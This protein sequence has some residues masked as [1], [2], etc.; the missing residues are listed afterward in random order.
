M[1]IRDELDNPHKPKTWDVFRESLK[2]E[3]RSLPFQQLPQSWLWMFCVYSYKLGLIRWR[4]KALDILQTPSPSYSRMSWLVLLLL[5]EEKKCGNGDY[6]TIWTM[7]YI[8]ANSR[9]S[10]MLWSS[11]HSNDNY[12]LSIKTIRI[13]YIFFRVSKPDTLIMGSKLSCCFRVKKTPPAAEQELEALRDIQR[14]VDVDCT[15]ASNFSPPNS[16]W[17]YVFHAWLEP[18]SSIYI[19]AKVLFVK[20]LPQQ[21]SQRQPPPP[22]VVVCPPPSG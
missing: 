20:N 4:K 21:V 19:S 22:L 3:L 14:E 1:A 15:T 9:I 8:G 12:I 11:E 6:L 10:T 13:W 17:K 18:R 7:N 16:H 5:D 2:V